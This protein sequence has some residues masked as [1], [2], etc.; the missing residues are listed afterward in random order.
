[1]HVAAC[2]SGDWGELVVRCADR[3]ASLTIVAP[4]FNKGVPDGL[5]AFSPPV[6][7]ITGDQGGPAK[8]ARDLAARFGRAELFELRGYASP[9]WADTVAERTA[10][11]ARTVGE[12]L[13]RAEG[14]PA[15]PSL[16]LPQGEAE[17]AGVRYHI[18]GQ[19]P[20]LLLLPLSLA[21]SQWEPLVPGL[22]DGYSVI[23]LGGAHFGAISLL[24][25][26]ASSGYGQLVA[27]VVNHAGLISG[28]AV[29]EV[30]CGSG[31]L[32][33]GLAKR[34]NGANSIV[35]TDVNPYLL[36]EAQALA[37]ADGLLETIRFEE[38]NGEALPYPD[39]HFDVAICCTVLEEGDADR[40]ISELARVTRP[41]GRVVVMTRAIDL[42]WSV[43]L[44][45]PHQLKGK[46][47]ALGPAT[48]S[49]VENHGCA[50]ASLY[51]RVSKAGLTPS[52]MG[53]QFAIY[54]DGDR[55]SDV[56]DRLM[57]LLSHDEARVCRAAFGQSETD[58]TVFVAEP[59][60]FA[61]GRK[62]A[63]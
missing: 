1:M 49:G 35:A 31:A 59:F 46:I 63:P 21:P 53:P 58:G 10:D 19:G 42:D 55:L 56:F 6:L 24:E 43:N 8:R 15:L 12:F 20:P 22:A 41:D 37:A 11:V 29:L 50:D 3:I 30:G 39:A 33:R 52:V 51:G 16:T 26:R 34:T 9:P 57:A 61:V 62:P 60:H 7:V 28:E 17:F 32:A 18:R 36:S 25:A 23:W 44:P 4:H 47:D 48:G 54:Q 40:M 27:Q 2:M 13:A 45:I 14:Q 5:D 38:A